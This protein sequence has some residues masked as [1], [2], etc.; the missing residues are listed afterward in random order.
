M[1]ELI[2]GG[3]DFENIEEV[4]EAIEK[5]YSEVKEKGIAEKEVIVDITRCQKTNSLAASIA[6]FA[7]GRRFQYVSTRDKKFFPMM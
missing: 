7:L 3:I 1:I 2:K 5:F 6:T 4:F